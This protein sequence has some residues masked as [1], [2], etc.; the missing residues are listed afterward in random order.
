[1]QLISQ[2]R[3]RALARGVHCERSLRLFS[4]GSS[5]GSSLGGGSGNGGIFSGWFGGSKKAS[6][7]SNNVD[8]KGSSNTASSDKVPISVKSVTNRSD[9]DK[10][11]KVSTR[12]SSATTAGTTKK[13]TQGA[14]AASATDVS[15]KSNPILNKSIP[16]YMRPEAPVA[17]P[18]ASSGD[19]AAGPVKV[20]G[21]PKE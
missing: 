18:P 9:F 4:S 6:S 1:M 20:R 12:S 10:S 21:P 17:V 15:V 13:N 19:G 14:S 5:Y 8:A 11:A 3:H 16:K 2:L 7:N